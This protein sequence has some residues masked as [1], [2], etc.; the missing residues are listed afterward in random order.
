MVSWPA[1]STPLDSARGSSSRSRAR[2]RA[3]RRRPR[4]RRPRRPPPR[5]AAK[6]LR[7]ER[8]ALPEPGVRTRAHSQAEVPPAWEGRAEEV[9]SAAAERRPQV[10]RGRGEV[11]L[12][13]GAAPREQ[14]SV[15]RA[16]RRSVARAG[17][18]LA[19]RAERAPAARAERGPAAR[20]RSARSPEVH[21]RLHSSSASARMERRPCPSATPPRFP[22]I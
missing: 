1:R 20:R 15:A 9:K 21:P 10:A 11:L 7:P 14:R 8:A 4:P 18:A 13:A 19:A 17:L 22:G 5:E 6:W 3:H 12:L 16:E 2:S